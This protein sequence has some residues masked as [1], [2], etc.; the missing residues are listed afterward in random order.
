MTDSSN[1][2]VCTGCGDEG[3][4][5]VLGN[6]DPSDPFNGPYVLCEEAFEEWQQIGDEVVWSH[7]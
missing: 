5:C 2:E 6:A 1:F 3:F 7:D 4:V